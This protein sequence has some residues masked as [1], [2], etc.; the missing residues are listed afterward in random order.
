MPA[1]NRATTPVREI[2]P[3]PV[4]DLRLDPE[5]PRLALETGATQL[6]ILKAMYANEALDELALSFARNGYF[7]EEPLVI[8]PASERSK[9]VVVEGNRRLAALKLLLNSQLRERIG[10]TDFPTV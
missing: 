2:V 7:W 5:N 6:A 1:R 3:R 9:F 8:V 10:V 4:A